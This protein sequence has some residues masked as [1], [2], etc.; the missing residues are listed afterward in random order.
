MAPMRDSNDVEFNSYSL[1][2]F[3]AIGRSLGNADAESFSFFASWIDRLLVVWSVFTVLAFIVSLVL[4]FGIIY[5]FIR[6]SQLDEAEEKY[7]KDAEDAYRQLHGE[8]AKN[9]RW[10]EVLNHVAG[11]NPNDWKLAIIEADIMLGEALETAGYAGASIGEKLKSISPRQMQSLDAAWEAHKI[12]NQIAHSGS[13][14][15]LTKK[16]A[17]ET[18]TRYKQVFDE[19]GVI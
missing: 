16:L 17:Q 12:R 19:F 18:V 14:F 4:L 5:A 2:F 3:G 9:W 10:N 11:D 8:R 6:G 7:I 15:V 13:D 1:D